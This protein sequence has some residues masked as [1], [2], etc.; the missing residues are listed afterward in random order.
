MPVNKGFVEI[1]REKLPPIPFE[2]KLREDWKI[3]LKTGLL[4][5]KL[6]GTRFVNV[7]TGAGG[8]SI[9][10]TTIGH[11]QG[12][13][14]ICQ[15]IRIQGQRMSS[16]TPDQRQLVA[17]QRRLMQQISVAFS[18]G[19][20]K[21]LVALY[22][23][24]LNIAES[25]YGPAYSVTLYEKLRLASS[26]AATDQRQ[27]YK[28]AVQTYRQYAEKLGKDHPETWRSM[29]TVM[30][31]LDH[32]GDDDKASLMGVR[33]IH[34]LKG[35]VAA[36]SRLMDDCY[37]VV[38]NALNGSVNKARGE[39][40]YG[41][42]QKLYKHLGHIARIRFGPGN[43]TSRLYAESE[44][45]AAAFGRLKEQHGKVIDEMVK[46]YWFC[47]ITKNSQKTPDGIAK[48][49]R[50]TALFTKYL[51][52]SSPHTL[53]MRRI[54]ARWY[55]VVGN[56]TG[57]QTG[58]QILREL[59]VAYKENN[60]PRKYFDVL[61]AIEADLSHDLEKQDIAL[62]LSQDIARYAKK[63]YARNSGSYA[64]FEYGRSL[65]SLGIAYVRKGDYQLAERYLLSGLPLIRGYRIEY[66]EVNRALAMEGL[67]RCYL[68]TSIEADL[69]NA[70]MILRRR[71]QPRDHAALKNY[72]DKMGTQLGAM[73]NLFGK[74]RWSLLGPMLLIHGRLDTGVSDNQVKM[75]LA[76]RKAQIDWSKG[77][78]KAATS[79]T[80]EAWRFLSDS[81][82][83]IVGSSQLGNEMLDNI[84]SQRVIEY[85]LALPESPSLNTQVL[86]EMLTQWKGAS[87]VQQKTI[88]RSRDQ[89][90]TARQVDDLQEVT[91]ELAKKLGRPKTLDS[92]K[93]LSLLWNRKS[94]IERTIR[95]DNPDMVTY[96]NAAVVD[97]MQDLPANAVLIDFF[98]YRANPQN[99]DDKATMLDAFVMRT[100]KGAVR[101]KLG[102]LSVVQR[103]ATEWQV[104]LVDGTDR[105]V[106]D[107]KG[108][109]LKNL[110]W[111]PLAEI[112]GDREHVLISPSNAM[113]GIPI[114]ALP[115]PN[116]NMYLGEH[117][118]FCIIPSPQVL[119]N[120]V[121]QQP[122]EYA[123]RLLTVG[124]I[125]YGRGSQPTV[126]SAYFAPLPASRQIVDSIEESFTKRYANG[127]VKTLLGAT[128]TETNVRASISGKRFVHIDSHG[129][130]L[131]ENPDAVA[132]SQKQLLG[133]A[134]SMAEAGFV[135]PGL[136]CGIAFANANNFATTANA[137]DGI[138]WSMESGP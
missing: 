1:A 4:D 77:N 39:N 78:V 135:H 83:D 40:D 109:V 67:A 13:N 66:A 15:S 10:L 82:T 2:S 131:Y 74:E 132:T 33:Q 113:A 20:A 70:F 19:D 120:L 55:A 68:E 42:C 106:V 134:F 28:L 59:A 127:E 105:S 85:L 111:N 118:R 89:A 137:H 58:R 86:Y 110:I 126:K 53:A 48:A 62:K 124:A 104:A 18:K 102:S 21:R 94:Q 36:D 128:A 103:A 26:L 38:D 97:I 30:R 99:P 3:S 31:V 24:N 133:D 123:P 51:G 32:I 69:L 52:S 79:G 76:N 130:Q 117:K 80:L 107:E 23:Q 121:N 108:R 56:E 116:N 122:P 11:E 54:L 34:A 63:E 41:R 14:I 90:K 114:W 119:A 98:P 44:E 115:G 71:Y 50:A 73:A 64:K 16:F 8:A 91:D 61:R 43:A 37:R 81:Q 112:I 47:A 75:W 49:E 84:L 46:L 9:K 35:F 57:K 125:D 95:S 138:L 88:R 65:I 7:Y 129:F 45:L 96:A 100:G 60:E 25:L 6:N 17:Q 12:S 101:F 93:E 29:T 87:F 27:A 92:T 136:D 5:V 72:Y 22:R